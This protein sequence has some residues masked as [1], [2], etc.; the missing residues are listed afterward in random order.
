MFRRR[1]GWTRPGLVFFALLSFS[2][3]A[4]AQICPDPYSTPAPGF[5]TNSDPKQETAQD[6]SPIAIVCDPGDPP[7]PPPPPPPPP[8]V[9]DDEYTQ[10]NY[11][12]QSRVGD[13]NGDGYTDVYIKR[14]TGN[15]NNG[16]IWESVGLGQASGRLSHQPYNYTTYAAARAMPLVDVVSSGIDIDED[17]YVDPTVSADNPATGLVYDHSFLSSGVQY[18]RYGKGVIAWDEDVDKY[19]ADLRAASIDPAYFA[20]AKEP[21]QEGFEV[22]VVVE[23]VFCFNTGW[24][25][26]CYVYQ[27]QIDLGFVPLWVVGIA[28]T[29]GPTSSVAGSIDSI[30]P[31]LAAPGATGRTSQKAQAMDAQGVN[32]VN[33]SQVSTLM[34]TAAERDV[35]RSYFGVVDNPVQEVYYCVWYCGYVWY[36]TWDGY[37]IIRWYDRWTRVTREGAFDDANFNRAAYDTWQAEQELDIALSALPGQQSIEEILGRSSDVEDARRRGIGWPF[38]NPGEII[39][40]KIEE[41]VSGGW[42]IVAR[43]VKV[44]RQRWKIKREC[45]QAQEDPE[46]CIAAME[47]EIIGESEVYSSSGEVIGGVWTPGEMDEDVMRDPDSRIGGDMAVLTVATAA[48]AAPGRWQCAYEKHSSNYDHVYY[49]ITSI[50]AAKGDCYDAIQKRSERHDRSARFQRHGPWRDSDHKGEIN[51][52]VNLIGTLVTRQVIRGREQQLI[53]SYEKYSPNYTLLYG[54]DARRLE[55]N[56]DDSP[57]FNRIRSVSKY[58]DLGCIMWIAA[59]ARWLFPDSPYTGLRPQTCP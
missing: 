52:T 41:S 15:S 16:V 53:D 42:D 50:A 57:L 12:Y 36:Y 51:A 24:F 8:I 44:L 56:H 10:L 14:L 29:A 39:V 11:D 59:K 55:T 32:A 25:P 1:E 17:G 31:V 6:G 28:S 21:D 49:G 20:N 2:G 26:Y 45:R 58:N 18:Q 48:A 4:Q 47:D 54:I 23:F 37:N 19:F 38:P 46:A 22:V 43:A 30:S 5:E 35:A 3:V 27:E 33:D 13:L 9:L 40:P 7:L 34:G